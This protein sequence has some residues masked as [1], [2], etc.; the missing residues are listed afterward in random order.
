[1]VFLSGFVGLRAYRLGGSRHPYFWNVAG[2]VSAI[3]CLESIPA[4]GNAF[5]L[6][7]LRALETGLSIVCYTL[8][9]LMTYPDRHLEGRVDSI[10]WGISRSDGSAG[11]DL[12]PSVSPTFQWIRLAQ[13]IPVRVHLD[14][15]PE[16]VALRV[17][18]TAAVLVTTGAAG[19]ETKPVPPVPRALQ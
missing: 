11:Y 5:N 9:T 2:F 14:E 12:L 16:D 18:T 13:R 8:V 19:E 17:D 15:V 6:A 10:G 4:T 7:V 3:I 1:M